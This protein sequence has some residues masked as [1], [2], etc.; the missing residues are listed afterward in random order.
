MT[1]AGDPDTGD[2]PGNCDLTRTK[3]A[4]ALVDWLAAD[5]TGSGDPDFLIIGDLNTYARK[6]RSTPSRRV[7][8]TR[9]GRATTTPTSS[10]SSSARTP[11]RTCSTGRTDTSTT[12]LAEPDLAGDRR[13][14]WHINSDEAD[15][16]DYDTTFK[17][18]SQ[19]ALYEPK[20][21]RSSDHDPVIVGLRL[22]A[23]P[24]VDANGPYTV[25]EG[26]SVSLSATG[27]DPNGDALSYA[28]V[29]RQQRELRDAGSDRH[30]LRG[31][32]RRPGDAHGRRAA[33]RTARRRRRTPQR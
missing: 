28:W 30:V 6:T 7:R 12:P 15:I 33:S 18:P 17:P 4:K 9:P 22:N 24:T 27:A 20:A 13:A 19:D 3:A 26:G 10:S 11:T 1:D 32:D 8:M 29:H 23:G 5:P 2:G 25:G 16:L 31:F 21:Y 14:E